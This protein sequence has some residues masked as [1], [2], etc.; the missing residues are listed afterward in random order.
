MNVE[1]SLCGDQL[2]TDVRAS[3]QA[4]L[5]RIFWQHQITY[6][7]FCQQPSLLNHPNLVVRVDGRML[8]WSVAAPLLV[9]LLA[10]R[11]SPPK[12]VVKALLLNE[13]AAT[14]APKAASAA[15]KRVAES[16]YSWLRVLGWSSQ[17]PKVGVVGAIQRPPRL[18]CAPPLIQGARALGPMVA[19]SCGPRGRC[20]QQTYPPLRIPACGEPAR[21]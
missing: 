16:S 12:E 1:L 9:S 14:S 8:R 10:F 7:Q 3:N 13:D 4:Q 2:P 11:R 21:A 20:R 19:R 6:E 17:A 5:D 18:G 15:T